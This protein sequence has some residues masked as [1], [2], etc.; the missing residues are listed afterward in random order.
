MADPVFLSGVQFAEC[1][2]P[3]YRDEHRVIAEAAVAPRRPS[4]SAWHLSAEE[5]DMAVG[6]SEG[7]NG[8]ERSAAVAVAEFPVNPSLRRWKTLARPGPPSRINPRGA[9]KRGNDETGIIGQRRQPRRFHCGP[10]LQRRV[11]L[12]GI[13]S[14][15]G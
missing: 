8:N 7:E 14:L 9:A 13:A 12:E 11:R 4:Q 3:A 15:L 5:L 1:Q 10:R 6:P 2:C